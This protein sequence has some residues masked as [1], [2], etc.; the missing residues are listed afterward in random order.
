MSLQQQ[1]W[2][3]LSEIDCEGHVEKKQGFDYLQWA[4]AWSQ[5]K[6]YFPDL[7]VKFKEKNYESGEVDIFCT[8]TIR[9]GDQKAKH[10]A[11]LPVFSGRGQ[12]IQNPN[13]MQVNNTKQR[14]MVKCLALFGLGVKYYGGSVELNEPLTVAVEPQGFVS[15][16]QLEELKYLIE[17]SSADVEKFLNAYSASTLDQ[18]PASQ[19]ANAIDT[20]NRKISGNAKPKKKAVK[21]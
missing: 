16:K 1:I 2:K 11:W 18:F 13:R 5:A 12:C 15:G 7:K 19:L 10:T 20:L 4:F 8:I 14:C 17:K 3:V 6:T 21:K 9:Q